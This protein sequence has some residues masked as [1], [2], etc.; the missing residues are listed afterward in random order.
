[1]SGG[2]HDRERMV[3]TVGR[4]AADRRLDHGFPKSKRINS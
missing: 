4:V 2:L 1:M 3:H